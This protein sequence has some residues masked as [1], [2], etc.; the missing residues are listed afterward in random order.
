MTKGMLTMDLHLPQR[1]VLDCQK[2]HD[3]AWAALTPEEQEAKR[4]ANRIENE[5]YQNKTMNELMD[6]AYA[7]LA[8]QCGKPGWI[9]KDL[10]KLTQHN[11]ILFKRLIGEDN[12]HWIAYSTYQPGGLCRGQVLINPEA[13]D[14][15]KEFN[16]G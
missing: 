6:E 16:N 9:Y 12:L 1:S 14:R 4:E 7:E 13:L 5:K 8:V 2:E 3:E 11:M 15:I 10:P